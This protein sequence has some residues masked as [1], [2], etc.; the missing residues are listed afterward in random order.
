MNLDKKVVCTNEWWIMINAIILL[1]TEAENLRGMTTP[2]QNTVTEYTAQKNAKLADEY[3]FAAEA[4]R[5]LHNEGFAE[6]V[7]Q[8]LTSLVEDIKRRKHND[9]SSTN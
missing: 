4:L 1:R 5:K 9:K 3:E 6:G 7:L 8:G 2:N